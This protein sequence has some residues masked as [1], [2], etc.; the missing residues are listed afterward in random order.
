MTKQI[1]RLHFL[2][3]LSNRVNVYLNIFLRLE[4]TKSN[5][6]YENGDDGDCNSRANDDGGDEGNGACNM[7][8]I[9]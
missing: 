8:N 1:V 3:F 6:Y 7:V 2:P 9:W 4:N 5:G